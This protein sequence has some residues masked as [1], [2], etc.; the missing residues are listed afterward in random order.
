MLCICD[1][2]KLPQ[3]W[4]DPVSKPIITFWVHLETT[5]GQSC[6]CSET[7]LCSSCEVELQVSGSAPKGVLENLNVLLCGVLILEK[8]KNLWRLVSLAVHARIFVTAKPACLFAKA[9][10]KLCLPKFRT[11]ISDYIDF[12]TQAHPNTW[13]L[14]VGRRWSCKQPRQI[15]VPWQKATSSISKTWWQVIHAIWR[16][17]FL[18]SSSKAP[19]PVFS[20][21]DCLRDHIQNYSGELRRRLAETLR[22]YLAT[23]PDSRSSLK[24]GEGFEGLGFVIGKTGSL[25]WQ[26]KL[27]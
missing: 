4:P 20:A 27:L 11:A 8:L 9:L 7:S 26:Q 6:F 24:L 17:H 14:P 12:R 22:E 16:S 15:Q 19:W 21:L 18:V 2:T 1:I 13:T 25:I 23:S 3:L 5:R 10:S